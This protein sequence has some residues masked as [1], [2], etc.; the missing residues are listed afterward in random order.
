MSTVP[1]KRSWGIDFESAELNLLRIAGNREQ[2]R[3]KR[4]LGIIR[5]YYGLAP[6]TPERPVRRDPPP[7]R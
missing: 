1:V 4:V 5:D 7:C 3:V 6:P 2:R